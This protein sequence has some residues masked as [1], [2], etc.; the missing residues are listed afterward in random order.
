[1]PDEFSS[2]V[3]RFATRRAPDMAPL[4]PKT[5]AVIDFLVQVSARFSKFEREIEKLQAA[6]GATA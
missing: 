3:A 4:Q 2:F 5:D 6:V 1:M